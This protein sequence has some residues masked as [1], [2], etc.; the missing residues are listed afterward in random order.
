MEVGALIARDPVVCGPEVSIRE[1]SNIMLSE[2]VG[3]VAV[4]DMGR[5][6]GLI[7]ER[8]IVRI[9]ASGT[10]PDGVTV[11][12]AM[13]ADP[14]TVEADVSTSEVADWFLAAGYRHLP[15]TRGGTL[16]GVISVKDILL[17]E[18]DDAV[19]ASG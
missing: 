14:D 17:T 13:T 18:S 3:S 4:L 10:G 9:V 19:G 12:E 16:V 15:V 7:T 1:A 2:Q 8:D 11:G 5:L 6:V